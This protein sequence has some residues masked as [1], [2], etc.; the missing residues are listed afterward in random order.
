M[1]ILFASSFIAAS[2]AA[3]VVKEIQYGLI[4]L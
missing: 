1:I 2:S 4:Y 3:A